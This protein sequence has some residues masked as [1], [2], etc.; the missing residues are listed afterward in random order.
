M[1]LLQQSGDLDYDLN[2]FGSQWVAEGAAL[3][4]RLPAVEIS[5]LA[6]ELNKVN[7]GRCGLAESKL[8]DRTVRIWKQRG[9]AWVS[10]FG[11]ASIIGL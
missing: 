8:G 9:Q 2:F 1:M 10:I 3:E 6:E 11:W 4:T 7:Y 5:K